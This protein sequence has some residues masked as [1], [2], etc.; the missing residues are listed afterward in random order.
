MKEVRDRRVRGRREV[1]RGMDVMGD[2]IDRQ[3]DFDR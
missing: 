2:S 1:K 3:S